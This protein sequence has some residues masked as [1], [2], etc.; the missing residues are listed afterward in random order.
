MKPI[1]Y[2]APIKGVTGCIYRNIYSRFFNG[3][4]I[5]LM[6][7]FMNIN[8]RRALLKDALPERND[9]GFTLV[10]QILHKDPK[11]FIALANR[12]YEIGYKTV[13]WN[14]GCPLLMIRKK[15]KGSGLL[16]YSDEIVK[17]LDEVTSGSPNQISIKVRLGSEEK[18]DLLRLLPMLNDLPLKEIIIHPRTGK[19]LY[20]GEVDIAAFEESLSLSNHTIVYNGDID[21][22]EKYKMLEKRFPMIDRWMI[23]RGGIT[24]PFLPEKIKG[25]DDPGGNGELDRFISF[26][27]A[28]FEAYQ[29]DLSEQAHLI[30]KMKEVWRYWAKAFEGG[31][32]IFKK[33]SRA[34]SIYKY[35]DMVD[36]FFRSRPQKA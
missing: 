36:R 30:K 16:P 25:I 34:K 18:S 35:S 29:S 33:L 1:L 22:L 2:M 26:H 4:D 27:S 6:P 9:A 14:L 15:K 19:Q 17:F 23:G 11:D 31:G 8:G 32:R 24:D 3:Y 7:F 10:P 20:E 5:A 12:L 21:S 13:N 28:L